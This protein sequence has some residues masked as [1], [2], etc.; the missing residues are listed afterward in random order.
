MP[1]RARLSCTRLIKPFSR[2]IFED[3][4]SIG[5]RS[6]IF[7]ARLAERDIRIYIFCDMKLQPSIY[8]RMYMHISTNFTRPAAIYFPIN[9][10]AHTRAKSRS[11]IFFFFSMLYKRVENFC[12]GF[13]SMPIIR[14][15]NSLMI[16]L[17]TRA[18]GHL[19]KIKESDGSIHKGLTYIK[20][21]GNSDSIELSM[22][23]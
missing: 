3:S 8:K 12:F 22:R 4:H 14:Q 11:C 13:H 9:H 1:A 6:L 23:I 20:A 17:F 10:V 16:K 21:D 7:P 5:A 19:S 18:E 2:E 15:L